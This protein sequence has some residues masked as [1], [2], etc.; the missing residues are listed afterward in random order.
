MNR[1]KRMPHGNQKVSDEQILAVFHDSGDPVVT[2]KEIS[3]SVPLTRQGVL[4]RL[5]ELSDEGRVDRKKTG[6]D[7]VWWAV[8]EV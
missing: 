3:Q 6:R 8:E 2:A 7:V 4:K 5:A 1:E